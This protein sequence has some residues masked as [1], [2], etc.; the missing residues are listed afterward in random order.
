MKTFRFMFVALAAALFTVSCEKSG[1]TEVSAPVLKYLTPEEGAPGYVIKVVGDN[2]SLKTDE[3]KVMFGDVESE[4]SFSYTDTLFVRVPQGAGNTVSVCV[5]GIAADKTLDFRYIKSWVLESLTKMATGRMPESST[6]GEATFRYATGLCTDEA[7][8]V[9]MAERCTHSIK[10][11][12]FDK[13]TVEIFA[14][15]YIDDEWGGEKHYKD[16]S[17]AEAEFNSPMDIVYAGDNTFYVADFMNNA[18]RKI[19]DGQVTTIGQRRTSDDDWTDVQM[20]EN[21]DFKMSLDKFK[22]S[23]P[24]GLL[25]D[26]KNNDLYVATQSHY[27]VRVDLDA[28]EVELY[29]GS[30]YNA[31]NDNGGRQSGK[32][33][34]PRGMVFD[35]AGNMYIANEYGHCISKVD[36]NHDLIVFAGLPGSA[37]AV[38]AKGTEA[39]FNEP[40]YIVLFENSLLVTD[41]RNHAVRQISLADA[42]VTTWAGV[43]EYN[44]MNDG[45]LSECRISW[46]IGL[47]WSYDNS[48]IYMTQGE[49]YEGLR[50]FEYR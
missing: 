16:G 29:A 46:P 31:G 45:G 32:L 30:P 41:F 22:F 39:K 37:G 9:Y 14:G 24:T 36:R 19:K 40:Q 34:C 23:R 28:S 47:T 5:N 2:F 15:K 38:D 4:I 43:L 10:K 49:T 3:N 17:L 26:G 25:Y 44:D 1:K 21:T 11:V 27:V 8:N 50:A 42:E 6:L 7:G 33:N 13:G 20:Y 12:S 18:V 48:R 35:N